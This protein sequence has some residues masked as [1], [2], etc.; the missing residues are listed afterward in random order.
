LKNWHE[1]IFLIAIPY[2]HIYG[3]IDISF[4]S[5]GP[6][7]LGLAY[8]AAF[9]RS[10]G[11][12]VEVFDMQYYQGGW[13]A[14]FERIRNERP[15]IVGFSSVTPQILSI[16]KIAKIIKGID[17]NIKIVT[18]GSHPSALP[19]E[20]IDYE[21]IDI[22]VVGEG[23]HTMLELS[24][25]SD[26]SNIKGICYR[27]SDGQVVVNPRRPLIEDLDT[28]PAPAY[29]LLPF[30]RYGYFALGKCFTVC[31]GRGCPY[32]CS[33][34]SSRVIFENR[35]RVNSPEY[36]VDMLE[37]FIHDFGIR[38]FEFGDESFT[39]K[40][41]RVINIC[42]LIMKRNLRI[43]WTCITRVNH[44]TNKEIVVAMKRAGCKMVEIGIESGDEHV[45]KQAHKGITL[46]QVEKAVT[47]LNEAGLESYGY[48][49]L[50]LPFETV[51]SMQ[52]TIDFS[53]KLKL[54]Y[55]QF[56][57]F[58]PLPGSKGW[59]IVKEGK[60]LKC[61]AKDWDDFC[62]Y[63]T[64]IV[65]SEQVPPSVLK[66]YYKKAMAEFYLRPY[67][68]LKILKKCRSLERLNMF[69]RMGVTFLNA[70]RGRD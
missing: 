9:L 68:Y 24:N 13:E 38:R 56:A 23:E 53:K 27:K 36:F 59:D 42:N 18:G 60:V 66:N 58:I 62:R 46:A 29:D 41:E 17:P 31:S 22:V 25:G 7:P 52:K 30:H 10:K 63:Q 3:K 4:M 44:I 70:I 64:P 69:M 12:Q 21:A 65:G 8:I 48:F 16:A 14:V 61:Y 40:P 19:E 37:K 11:K 49:I 6:P 34:C 35:Y 50:G 15:K 1:K 39:A 32:N 20:T 2:G 57:M 67:M 54:D 43:K 5:F 55:A 45:L 26:L 33:F 28:L 51:Q 47:L